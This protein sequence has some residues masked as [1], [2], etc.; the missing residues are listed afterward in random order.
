MTAFEVLMVVACVLVLA[1]LLLPLLAVERTRANRMNCVSNLKQINI[2]LRIWEGDNGMKYPMS[3]S[4]TNGGAM[5]LMETGNL[6]GCFQVAS[7]EIYV[8][9]VL[10]CPGDTGRAYAP[11]WSALNGSNISYFLSADL[12]N[13]DN[14]GGIMDGDD[15]LAFGRRLIKPGLLEIP[16]NSP[17]AWS[18]TRHGFEGNIGMADGSVRMASSNDLQHAFQGTR[19]ATNRIVIP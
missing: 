11:D 15:N 4:V 1:A 3:V 10:V 17:V 16:S 5:E 12:S 8:T 14:P 2:A 6:A 13:S 7:N 9:K 18:G 19:L